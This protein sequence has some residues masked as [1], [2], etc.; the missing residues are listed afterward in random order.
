MMKSETFN[1][2]PKT[3]KW[4]ENTKMIKCKKNNKNGENKVKC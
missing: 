3:I 1:K 4:E 2:M